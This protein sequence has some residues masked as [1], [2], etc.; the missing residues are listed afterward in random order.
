M[1]RLQDTIFQVRVMGKWGWRPSISRLYEFV[2][3]YL[4]DNSKTPCHDAMGAG[5][6]NREIER[7][8]LD[9]AGEASMSGY[10]HDGL[11]FGIVLRK[12]ISAVALLILVK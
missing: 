8:L 1:G 4:F 2:T 7:S 6:W 9:A 10:Y 11:I 3:D 12:F 5:L